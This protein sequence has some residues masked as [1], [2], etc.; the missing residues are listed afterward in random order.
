MKDKSKLR[1]LCIVIFVVLMGALLVGSFFLPIIGPSANYADSSDDKSYSCYDI[2]VATNADDMND[3]T[4]GQLEAFYAIS[5]TE[6]RAGRCMKIVGVL[7]MIV[8][9]IG[10]VLAI[11]AICMPLFKTD[12]LRTVTISFAFAAL[13]V[14]IAIL[15]IVCIYLGIE[16]AS[17]YPY[18]Y[19]YA[20]CAAGFVM[21]GASLFG[22]AGAWFL[23]FFDKEKAKQ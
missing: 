13:A 19:Y 8:A 3:L 9:M 5:T 2:V 6:G 11:C 16:T 1:N 21:L 4:N 23:G 20:I 14:S 17:T 10:A 18:S 15:T 7:G 22:G 12:M